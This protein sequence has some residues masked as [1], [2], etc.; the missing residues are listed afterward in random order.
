GDPTSAIIRAAHHH[1][2]D[3]VVIGADAR[4]WLSHLLEGSVERGLLREA[5]FAV[6]VV[7]ADRP[8]ERT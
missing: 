6:L 7:A 1:H 3:V 8:I 5:D 2:A 4:S